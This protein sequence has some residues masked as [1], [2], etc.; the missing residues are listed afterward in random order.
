MTV[1]MFV[2]PHE[3]TLAGIVPGQTVACGIQDKRP[4]W[5]FD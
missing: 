3:E 4:L 1:W 5:L 2:Q